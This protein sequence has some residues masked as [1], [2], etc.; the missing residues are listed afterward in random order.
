MLLQG[1]VVFVARTLPAV[2]WWPRLP[3]HESPQPQTR[4]LLKVPCA[5]WRLSLPQRR[6]LSWWSC[7]YLCC[8]PWQP[9][10]CLQRLPGRA[11]RFWE[12]HLWRV[13][14]WWLCIF[15]HCLFHH[16]YWGDLFVHRAQEG[17]SITVG[18]RLPDDDVQPSTAP[19][20]C[21]DAFSDA[22]L[23]HQLEGALCQRL[24]VPGILEFRSRDAE[25]ELCDDHG[26][27][28]SFRIEE[29]RDPCA[30]V[31]DFG[32]TLVLPSMHTLKELPRQQFVENHGDDLLGLLHC[33]IFHAVGAFP[34][35]WPSQW[36]L[37][38]KT[39][40]NRILRWRGPTPCDVHHRRFLDLL[41]QS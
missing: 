38:L 41:I 14:R 27:C 20:H 31:R 17:D 8:R 11:A 21:P 5:Q 24:G 22:A 35:P 15:H 32:G 13:R 9:E 16:P 40:C 1:G 36:D 25:R 10:H 19:G 6:L 2:W 29:S 3:W 23:W 4:I 34:M 28:G 33:P 26:S 30:D 39:L 37:H 12:W 18:F 7:R